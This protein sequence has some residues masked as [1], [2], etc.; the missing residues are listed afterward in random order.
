MNKDRQTP[1]FLHPSTLCISKDSQWVTTILGSCVAVCFFDENQNIGGINHY[2]LPYW[3]GDGLESPKYG[4]VAIVQLFQKMLDSGAKK[5]DIVCKIFGGA[6]VL[7]E[8][9][10]VFNVGQRNIELAYKLISE[11]GISVVSSSTGGKQGRKIHF[12][13]G[14]GEVLQKYL[15]KTTQNETK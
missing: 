5:E 7:G 3:N 1:Y 12:N 8:Q 4:N 13:T 14:T 11:L 2:M 6:E 15:D 9:H 10:S